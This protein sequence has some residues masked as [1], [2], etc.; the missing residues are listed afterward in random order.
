MTIVGETFTGLSE[1]KVGKGK[2]DLLVSALSILITL[3][4][5]QTRAVST[6]TLQVCQL[7]VRRSGQDG[8]AGQQACPGMNIP[9]T[10]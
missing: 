3:C 9:Q 5:P 10:K 8:A 1:E 7:A 2:D 6:Y 4:L